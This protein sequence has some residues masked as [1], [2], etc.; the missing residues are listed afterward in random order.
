MSCCGVD[1]L[2]SRSDAERRDFGAASSTDGP[3]GY[4]SSGCRGVRIILDLIVEA[5]YC[6]NECRIVI[7]VVRRFERAV[8]AQYLAPGC[9]KARM[10]RD[11]HGSGG[12]CALFRLEQC[13]VCALHDAHH[14][15]RE[16]T[17]KLRCH[18]LPHGACILSS[19]LMS[20]CPP[21]RGARDRTVRDAEA[22]PAVARIHVKTIMSHES[23][24]LH[25]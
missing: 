23:I 17:A 3:H 12:R 6:H 9:T 7:D 15:R 10:V 24:I 18:L 4:V 20:G 21:P 25:F 1:I 19:T 2:P 14:R 22:K 8:S 16:H 13:S 11:G 5:L